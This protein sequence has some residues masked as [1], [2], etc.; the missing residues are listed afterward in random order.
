LFA[1]NNNKKK[2]G[3]YM[4][5]QTKTKKSSLILRFLMIVFLLFYAT[6]T[7]GCVEKALFPETSI[8]LVSVTPDHIVPTSSS[9]VDISGPEIT[10]RTI[11]FALRNDTSIP[12]NIVRYSINYKTNIDEPIPQLAVHN[13]PF[14]MELPGGAT[15][16]IT[17]D[18]STN[19][20]Y[21][22]DVMD[23]FINTISKVWPIRGTIIFEMKDANSN[24]IF[25]EASFWLSPP[26]IPPWNN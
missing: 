7:T 25:K 21:T 6:F 26:A 9:T 8:T 5:K 16:N 15:T 3:S 11:V 19:T 13:F 4:G 24:T 10:R 18:G 22:Q 12:A 20:L 2:R 23:F 1:D 14:S 17:F